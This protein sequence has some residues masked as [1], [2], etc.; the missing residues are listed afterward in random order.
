MGDMTWLR[1]AQEARGHRHA[2]NSTELSFWHADQVGQLMC[3]NLAVQWDAGQD[4]ELAQP[5]KTGEQLC[6]CVDVQSATTKIHLE[7]TDRHT[8][9]WRD[10][11]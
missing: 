6:L 10:P 8:P 9:C 2:N 3:W 5:F 7:M 11:V 4:L 1:L